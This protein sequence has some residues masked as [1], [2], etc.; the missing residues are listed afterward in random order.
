MK[1]VERDNGPVSRDG[2]RDGRWVHAWLR[3]LCRRI[4]LLALIV[5]V[6]DDLFAQQSVP[7]GTK[8]APIEFNIS[9]QPLGSAL[10]AFAEKTGWQVSVPTELVADRTSSG[11]S[12]IHQPE[13]ALQALLAGTGLTYSLTEGN[14][15]TLVPGAAMP[16]VAA[17]SIGGSEA[18]TPGSQAGSTDTTMAKPIK[19]SEIVVK[20]KRERRDSYT[21]DEVSSATRIPVPVH[22]TPRSVEV[23]TRQVLDDQ[24]V[25][26][27]SEALRNVSGVAESNTQGGRAGEFTI[28]GFAS[29]F[30]VFKN[31]FRDDATF[32]STTARDIINLERIE[33]V[34]G[35]PSYLYGRG[36]PGGVI[37]QITKAPLK[38]PYYSAEM[39]IGSYNLYR[40]Q[41]DI[42]GP[43]NASKTLTFRFNGMFESSGSYRE[44][45]ESTRTFLAPTIGWEIGPRTT[46][47]FEGEY[48][49]SRAP[50][51]RGLT[52]FGGGVLP[53]PIST[54]LGDPARMDI[55]QNGK[56]TLIL[57]HDFNDMF[58]WRTG[59]RAAVNSD[60]YR[61]REAWF[62]VGDESDG[63]LNLAQFYIPKTS[64]SYYLQNEVHGNFSTGPIKHKAIVGIE[65]GREVSDESVADDNQGQ[66]TTVQ[67]AFSYIN[68]FNPADRLFLDTPLTTTSDSKEVNG[69]LG[70]YFGDHLSLTDKLHLHAGGR[71][72]YF[73]QDLTNRPTDLDPTQTEEGLT[74]TA[75][76]PSVGL[77]YQ[78]WK[79]I[80][81][82]ANYTESFMP[83]VGTRSFDRSL[84]SPQR[85]KAYEGGVK[86]RFFEDRLR[87]TIAGFHI[88]KTNVPTIDPINGLPFVVATGEQRSQGIEFDVAGRILPGWDLIGNYAYIDARVTEDNE[89]LVGSRLPN[90]PLNQGSLWTTYF[91]QEGPLKGLGAG[92]GMYAQGKRNGMPQ[93]Q[94][95]D[96][97]PAPYELPGFVRM[98]AAVYYRKPEIFT[99]TNLLAAV[100]F[101]NLL[102]QRY[103]TGTLGIREVVYTG[104]PFTVIGSVKLEFF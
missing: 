104:A 5:T 17:P 58:R 10:N 46:L 13:A 67:G 68:V 87:A 98:D 89:F 2:D 47:R 49:Y 80:A 74:D 14:A 37:N 32:A 44:G 102:D 97:C 75:F 59:F 65:L 20:E 91:L 51:D 4:L 86:F 69:I 19:V 78:P 3:D 100:N 25:T 11:I 7:P 94:N 36:D 90:V 95:P 70:V 12:G 26:R 81:L 71:F 93:C 40:P 41:F 23:V 16:T 66:D 83:N 96:D 61:S 35:P 92:L 6:A 9:A 45:V 84:L 1:R 56:A 22:D 43:L 62:Y 29:E 64:Q 60:Q 55:A 63:I 24:K 18:T 72:D 54:F 73:K 79:P 101:T 57:L 21:V 39:L 15:V 48:L 31:G 30:N 28:R 50:I 38:N 76:S 53:I 82:Y 52:A 99:R 103:F 34:K 88:N 27:F 8:N 85:G 33:V 42:G 77:T